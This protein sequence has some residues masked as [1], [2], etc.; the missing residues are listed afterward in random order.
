MTDDTSRRNVSGT[1]STIRAMTAFKLMRAAQLRG[2]GG[3]ADATGS[4]GG[5]AMMMVPADGAPLLQPGAVVQLTEED[6]RIEARALSSRL[7]GFRPTGKRETS[8]RGSATHLQPALAGQNPENIHL[9]TPLLAGVLPAH[10]A[11][12]D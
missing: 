9:P 10:G 8:G 4:G 6:L 3:P 1:L 5:G 11:Q 7:A 12:H 2:G